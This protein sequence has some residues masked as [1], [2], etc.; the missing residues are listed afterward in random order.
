MITITSN[1]KGGHKL[2]GKG[3]YRGFNPPHI[4]TGG[5]GPKIICQQTVNSQRRAHTWPNHCVQNLPK[6]ITKY[7]TDRLGENDKKKN[8]VFIFRL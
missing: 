5:G 3:K 8:G 4:T 7:Q 2:K 1:V 6:I